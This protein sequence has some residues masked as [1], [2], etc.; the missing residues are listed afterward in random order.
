MVMPNRAIDPTPEEIRERCEEIQQGWTEED[1]L[2]RRDIRCPRDYKGEWEVP[3]VKP[4][5]FGNN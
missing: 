1:F 3:V 2:R 4:P 5:K